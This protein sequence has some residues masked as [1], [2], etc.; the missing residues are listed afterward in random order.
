MIQWMSGKNYEELEK[1]AEEIKITSVGLPC[2]R[3]EERYEVKG[4]NK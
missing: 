3:A 1:Q 2:A 4:E